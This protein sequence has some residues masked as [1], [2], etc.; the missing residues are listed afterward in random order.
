MTNDKLLETIKEFQKILDEAEKNDS[1]AFPT[2]VDTIRNTV[3]ELKNEHPNY[4]VLFD[5]ITKLLNDFNIKTEKTNI[6]PDTY[7]ELNEELKRL[8]KRL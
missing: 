6:S 1:K 3:E 5:E 8:F 7:K 2:Q 4:E